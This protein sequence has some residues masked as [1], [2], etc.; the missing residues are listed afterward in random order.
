FGVSGLLI[1]LVAMGVATANSGT[2]SSAIKFVAE[3]RGAGQEQAIPSLLAYLRRAQRL[4]LAA[5]LVVGTVV[6]LLAGDHLAGDMDRALLLGFL[7][8]ATSLRAAYMFNVG[9]A[10]GFEDFRG[11]A[12][13]SLVS[14]P[15]NLL[16]V[17]LAWQLGA[18]VEGLLLVFVVSGV[19]FHAMSHW[20]VARHAP[21]RGD[22]GRPPPPLAPAMRARIRR[23]MWLTAMIVSVGFL[24]ASEVEVLFLN[25]DGDPE[26]A[27]R[28]KVAYQLAVGAAALVPGV[29]G[30]LLLP[31]MAN[32]LGQGRE[33][34]GRRFVAS[35]GYL[36]LLAAPLVAF[37]VVFGAAAV[38][39]LY[40][41][42]YREAAPV[43]AACLLGEIG[44]A[45]CRERG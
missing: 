2:A 23:H 26:G 15:L 42:A 6:F 28:F 29:F 43:F 18:P 24:A 14:T 35:T 25:L 13:V 45:S 32:A 4:F 37:G 11:T 31:M 22:A 30:A 39:A 3:L 38:H 19:V 10:K 5:V 44:R 8:V 27:G 16:M 21:A 34:A 20:M 17:V 41:D 40:G 1:W 33:V 36:V 7:L 12:V 9:V